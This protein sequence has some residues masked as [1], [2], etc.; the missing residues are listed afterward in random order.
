[1]KINL[2]LAVLL[3]IALSLFAIALCFFPPAGRNNL[4]RA[5]VVGE[6]QTEIAPDSALITFSVVTQNQ[7]AVS[8]QQENARKSE[9]VQQS[10]Q[11]VAGN[12]KHE[13]KTSDYS[14]QPEQ[15]YSGK[16][17][18]IVGYTARNTVTITIDDLKTVGSIIDAATKAGAN[19]VEN[20]S[21]VVREDSP[22]RGGSLALAARQ[23]MA[24]AES[25]AGSLGG[26]VVR[27]IESHESGS[28]P[29][30]TPDYSLAATMSNTGTVASRPMPTTPIKAGSLEM[31]ASIVLTVEIEIKR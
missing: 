4:T 15:D 21:F 26:R 31:R 1:M 27:V 25:V 5:T 18:K 29:P 22:A 13:I 16:M 30:Q 7:Q 8:A 28:Q 6:A 24:K 9:A 19:S 2:Q 23:A 17:A 14:L 12:V 11:T 10:I 20:V 3:S